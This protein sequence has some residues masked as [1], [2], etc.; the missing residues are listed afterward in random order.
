[1][2]TVLQGSSASV[3]ELK[4]D[5]IEQHW[6]VLLIE[7]DM[8]DAQRVAQFLRRCG[9]C[10]DVAHCSGLQSALPLLA[11]QTFD[12]VIAELPPA[13]SA[14]LAALGRLHA[15]AGDAALIAISEASDDALDA[16]LLK[17]GAQRHLRKTQL[18]RE[19]LGRALRHAVAVKRSE[20]QP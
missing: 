16:E 3:P 13:P 19:T 1:M 10:G 11:A 14:G 9:A 8:R 12:V 4:E 6:S 17:L 7:D 15:A 18:D 20:R 5:Q 2:Q